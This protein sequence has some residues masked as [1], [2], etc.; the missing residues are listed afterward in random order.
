M[1]RLLLVLFLGLLLVA[2]AWAT[3]SPF[4][5]DEN[6]EEERLQLIEDDLPSSEIPITLNEKVEYFIRYFTTTKRKVFERWLA[7]S[8]RYGPMIKEILRS[9]GLPEDLVYLAMIESGFNPFAYSRAG[10]CGIWQ[11]IRS[12]GR[13][14]GLKIDYWVD[15]RRDPEKATHAAAKYL[16]ELYRE[17]ECWHLASAS[18][19]AGEAK[20]RKAIRR[21]GTR[22]FWKLSRYRYLKRETKNY[23][24]KMIAAMIIAKNPEKF[25]FHV[26]PL[27]PLDYEIVEVPGGTD[28]R[29]IALA[30]GTDYDLIRLLNA[31]LRRGKTPPYAVSYPVKVPF[32]SG[33]RVEEALKKVQFVYTRRSLRHRVR[34]GESLYQI[35][36]YYG[37]SIR[38]LKRANRLRSNKLRIGMVLRIP[39]RTQAVLYVSSKPARQ[40][41]SKAVVYRVKRGD[42][43][44][45]IAKKF[46]VSPRDLK[47]WNNLRSNLIRPGLKLVIWPEA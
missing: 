35:A 5:R 45:E 29:A 8:G 30:S 37:V 14:Y 38:A 18:Y 41:K 20:L 1:H 26:D 39:V 3:S 13:K 19:N 21:Y 25:G 11:F 24:P 16:L 15:E 23:V 46:G 27:P 9:Y 12:T 28:L 40:A 33:A 44:W 43:L 4:D 31:E 42:S 6:I 36:N 34:R 7:R 17:F 32:G 22:D 2:N 47:V 10:A